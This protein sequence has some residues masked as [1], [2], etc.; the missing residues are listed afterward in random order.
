MS[1]E[2]ERHHCD[3]GDGFVPMKMMDKR[4]SWEN[5]TLGRLLCGMIVQWDFQPIRPHGQRRGHAYVDSWRV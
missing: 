2:D 5:D 3:D 1:S 4:K